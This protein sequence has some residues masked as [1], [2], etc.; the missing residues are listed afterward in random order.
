MF[1]KD[2]QY[3]NMIRTQQNL[4]IDYQ[5]L[6]NNKISKSEQSIFLLDGSNESSDVLLKIKALENTKAKTFISA[7]C[8]DETQIIQSNDEVADVY[9]NSVYF[10]TKN[11]ITVQNSRIKESRNMYNNGEIDYLISPYSILHHI[12]AS[13][14]HAS[15]LNLLILNDKI[16]SIILDEEKRLSYSCIKSLT[17]Y[18]EITDS[19]FFDDEISRQKLYEE[20]YVLELQTIISD[21]SSEFY[22]VNENSYFLENIN[23]YYNL[24]QL[25]NEQISSLSKNLMLDVNYN[26]ISIDNTLYALVKKQFISKQNLIFPRKKKSSSKFFMLIIVLLLTSIIAAGL[27]YYKQVQQDEQIKQEKILLEKAQKAKKEKM[28]EIALVNHKIVN[29]EKIA[30]LIKLFNTIGIDS[31]LKEIKLQKDESTLVYNFTKKDSYENNLKPKLL[32]LYEN[33][34]NILSSHKNELFTAIISNTNLKN[35]MNKKSIKL[36]KPN[37]KYKFLDNKQSKKYLHTLIKDSII[38]SKKQVI[39]KYTKFV[40]TITNTIKTPQEF[41][42]IIKVINE[43]YYS[44]SLDYPIEFT[45]SKDKLKVSYTI[46]FNQINKVK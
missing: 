16:Y 30:F 26:Q 24:K 12:L 39:K 42:D 29:E 4:K 3:I 37:K 14:L 6:N 8:E 5:L 7:L 36:Y 44:I 17:P 41:Y 10:D 11:S 38:V 23:I 43:Q 15:S 35:K 9:S 45:K 22:K 18:H 19:S 32:E 27:F 34:E 33:S 21:I 25:S 20:M 40:Y 28:R 13:D 2:T 46:S 1:N 31:V